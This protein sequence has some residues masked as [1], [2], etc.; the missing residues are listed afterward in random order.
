MG[1]LHIRCKG[2]NVIYDVVEV[3][4]SSKDGS[5]DLVVEENM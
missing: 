3:Q 2:R 5:S 1:D 4:R